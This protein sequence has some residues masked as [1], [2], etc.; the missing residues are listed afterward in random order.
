[1]ALNSAVTPEGGEIGRAQAVQAEAAGIFP[2]VYM[3]PILLKPKQDQEAQVVV[4]GKPAADMSARDYRNDFLP[5][6]VSL[7]Q[8]CLDHLRARYEVLVI[9]GAGSPAEVNLKDRDIVNM[10]TAELAEAP[11]LLV[12]DID[13]GGVFASLIGTMDLLEPAEKQRVKGLIIN[14]FR[15]DISLFRTGIDFLQERTGV[16]VLGVIP[17][18]HDHGIAEEDS[19]SLDDWHD[20]GGKEAPVQIAVIQLPRISNFTDLDPFLGLP[21]TRVRLV[22]KGEAIGEADIIIIPGTKN[23]ILDLLYLQEQGYEQE[24]RYLADQGKYI[25]G[26]CGGYQMMGE[27]LL[28]PWGSEAGV[29]DQAGLGLL[30]LTTC[31]REDKTTHEVSGTVKAKLGFWKGISGQPVRGYEI[32]SGQAETDNEH[33]LVEI[34]RRSGSPVKIVDGLVAGNGKIFGTHLHGFFN[35]PHILLALI[36]TVRHEKG[37][38]P[39][40]EENLPVIRREQYYDRLAQTVRDALDMERIYG[41]MGLEE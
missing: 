11:V 25:A 32:H 24:I 13:R 23:T 16:P 36:N 29:G 9:E 4:M 35:N 14:K 21:D 41:I 28:D 18:I 17:Y 22:K 30:P 15:G 12:A 1:M 3:N 2:S 40:M 33:G 38:A 20:K 8:S 26:L 19:V 10:K 31:Y 37:M 5:G 7:V 34:I 6:A 39:L 27:K